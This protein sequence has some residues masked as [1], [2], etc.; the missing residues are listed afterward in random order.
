MTDSTVYVTT[1]IPFVN[2]KPHVGFALELVQA[3]VFARYKRLTGRDVRFQT[4]TDEHAFKNVLAARELN[5]STD[6]FVN[7]NASA[8]RQLCSALNISF[9]RFIRTTETAHKTGVVSFWKRLRENDLYRKKYS[10]LYCVGCEDFLL[11]RDLVDGVC[12]DHGK[13]PEEVQEENYFFRLSA[14]QE[15]LEEVRLMD[16]FMVLQ[17]STCRKLHPTS[18][19]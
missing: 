14:Y 2:A 3:D 6:R 5:I 9:T 18:S 10:G 19:F 4:G 1:T 17:C 8:F 16:R 15:Q 11:E 7:S 12:P 13:A